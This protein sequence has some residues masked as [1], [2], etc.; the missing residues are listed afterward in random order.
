MTNRY[1]WLVVSEAIQKAFIEVDEVGTTAAATTAS[2][3]QS[4]GGSLGPDPKEFIADHPFLFFVRDLQ[5][6]L[7][8][9]QGRVANPNL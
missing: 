5:T 8:L 7:L 9:F 1:P 4:R 2:V 6:G 3:V